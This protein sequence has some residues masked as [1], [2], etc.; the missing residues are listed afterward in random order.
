MG[1]YETGKKLKPKPNLAKVEPESQKTGGAGGSEDQ[2]AAQWSQRGWK[3]RPSG[4]PGEFP[5]A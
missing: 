1:T 5:V 4:A 2:G 3:A